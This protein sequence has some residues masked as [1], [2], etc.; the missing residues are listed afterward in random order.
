MPFSIKNAALARALTARGYDE[1]TAVQSAVLSPEAEDRDLLVS[2]QTGSGKTV[3]Y[4]LALASTIMS[5]SEQLPSTVLPLVLIIA[6]TRELALQVHA[7]LTWLYEQA[8]GRIVS[9]VGG[10]DARREQRLLAAGCHMVVGPPGRLQD[11]INRG[12]LKLSECEVVVLD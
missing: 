2:A 3:A 4:G 7:E 8:G 10:M 11:H 6:P 1:P 9:C 12:Y 5:E